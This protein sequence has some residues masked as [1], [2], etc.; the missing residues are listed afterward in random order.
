[1]K[2]INTL[3]LSEG[4]TAFEL[5]TTPSASD[6]E[7]FIKWSHDSNVSKYVKLGTFYRV[8][9]FGDTDYPCIQVKKRAPPNVKTLCALRWG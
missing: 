7:A 5:E 1:M 9:M 6:V 3:I 4:Q 8:D 2:V